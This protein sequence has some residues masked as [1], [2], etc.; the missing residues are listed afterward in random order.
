MRTIANVGPADRQRPFC[1]NSTI[2]GHLRQLLGLLQK[3]FYTALNL[4]SIRVL[5]AAGLVVALW[6]CPIHVF[7]NLGIYL[8]TVNLAA[9]AVFGR[10]ELLVVGARNERQCTDAVHLCILTGTGVVVTTLLV[11]IVVKHLFIAYVSLFFAGTLLSRAWLRLGLMLATRHGRYDRAVKALA[12]HAIGQPLILVILIYNGQD[13]F[14]AFVLSDFL[15]QL[16]AAACVCVSEWHSFQIALRAQIRFRRISNLASKN[17]CL[18]TLNLTAAASVLLFATAPLFFLSG[19]SNGILAGTLALLFRVLDVPTTLISASLSSIL[20]KEVAD[21]RRNGTLWSLAGIFLLPAIIAILVF[22]LISIG[23]LTINSLE[24]ASSWQMALA[25]CPVVAL[26]QAGIAAAAPLMDIAALTGRQYGLFALN[27]ISVGLAGFV[28]LLWRGDPIFAILMAGS[29]GFVRVAAISI[30]L[31]GS[32][33]SGPS[34]T[35]RL[36]VQTP[37]ALRPLA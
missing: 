32:G 23:G 19:L 11:A 17:L 18:P 8:A 34:M 24:I 6:L 31:V 22:G 3:L 1:F 9:L 5:S 2:D 4:L 25:L 15:G 33:K 12:P 30:W 7:A 20:L 10:Y 28:L 37:G 29:I 13:P 16:I 35:L 14:L 36:A 27:I 26:F 21:H